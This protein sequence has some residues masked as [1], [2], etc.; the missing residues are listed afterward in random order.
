MSPEILGDYGITCGTG[1]FQYFQGFFSKSRPCR[2]ARLTPSEFQQP[3]YSAAKLRD[4]K[5]EG[6]YGSILIKQY[7][8]LDS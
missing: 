4:A 8:G 3:H 7:L 5:D 6:I 1:I 2:W